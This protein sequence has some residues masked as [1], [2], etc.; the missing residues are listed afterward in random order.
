[1]SIHFEI[2]KYANVLNQAVDKFLIKTEL[3]LI[4]KKY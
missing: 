4:K 1:M 3:I 2:V